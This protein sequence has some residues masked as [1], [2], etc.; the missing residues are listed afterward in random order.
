METNPV[1]HLDFSILSYKVHGLEQALSA[2][3]KRIANHYEIPLVETDSKSMLRALIETLAQ[4]NTVAILVD[5]YDKP[6]TDYIDDL[7]KAN[8]NREVLREFYGVL[9]PLGNKI[10]ML[11]ITGIAKFTRV[12][13]FSVLNHLLDISMHPSYATLTGITEKELRHYFEDR[14]ID[15]AQQEKTSIEELLDNIKKMYNGY[16]WDGKNFVYNP[17]SLFNFF[18]S[19]LMESYWFAT[20]TPNFLI[21]ILRKHQLRKTQLKKTKVYGTFFDSLDIRFGLD[22]YPLLFQTG[23]TTIKKIEKERGKLRYI[24][25]YPNIE[26]EQAFIQNLIEAITF[27][28]PTIVNQALIELEDALFQK[29]IE[30]IRTQLNVLFADLSY[31]FQP[32]EKKKADKNRLEQEFKAWEGWFHTVIHLILQFIG[33]QIHCEVTKHLGRIDAVIEVTDYL[34]IIE[35]KLDKLKIGLKQI[36][37]TKYARSYYNSTKEIILMGITF[38]QKKREVKKI[39]WEVW[40][41]GISNE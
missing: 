9:K 21:N 19:G 7:A 29:D 16:S 41:R 3:L 18:E 12:S 17:F 5:E 35:F 25:G 37:K 13:L 40:E 31:L 22:P 30:G 38:N 11:F 26:V 24:L 8:T 39:E 15:L 27:K 14:L 34:Y 32:F 28:T 1:I 2:E 10:Q 36:K 20:G 33:I 23:Y 4:K 6:I